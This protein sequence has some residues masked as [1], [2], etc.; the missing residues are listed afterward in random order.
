MKEFTRLIFFLQVAQHPWL[1]GVDWANLRGGPAPHVPSAEMA[2]LLEHLRTCPADDPGFPH[3][4]LV[5][6]IFDAFDLM[7]TCAYFT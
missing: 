3:L 7:L 2:P 6:H 5:Q 1:A 4:V